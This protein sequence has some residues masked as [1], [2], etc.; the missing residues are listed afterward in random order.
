M[1][2]KKEARRVGK[3]EIK[4]QLEDA[5]VWIKTSKETVRNL[6]SGSLT[7]SGPHGSRGSIAHRHSF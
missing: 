4:N 5:E 6:F 3:K 1:G 7:T 2:M